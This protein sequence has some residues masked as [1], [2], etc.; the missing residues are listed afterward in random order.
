MMIQVHFKRNKL[1]LQF[2]PEYI[3]IWW[4]ETSKD[5]KI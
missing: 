1:N 5:N 3:L 2:V 4:K